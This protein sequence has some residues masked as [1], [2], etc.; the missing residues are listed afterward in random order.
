MKKTMEAQSQA[1]IHLTLRLKDGTV[2]DS[3]KVNGVPLLIRMGDGSLSEALEKN[4][5]GMEEG[6]TRSFQLSPE[7]SFGQPNPQ[8]FHQ[9]DKNTFP[10]HIQLKPGVIVEFQQMN[11]QTLPGTIRRLEG[12]QVLVDFNHPLC[13]QPVWFE[14]ELLEVLYTE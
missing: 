4:L 14:V 9:V 6:E 1:L 5:C 3:S 8:N 10:P 2:A 11:G 13:G 12:E 7:E